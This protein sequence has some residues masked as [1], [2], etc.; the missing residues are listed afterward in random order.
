ME[1]NLP[2]L[3]DDTRQLY[4]VRVLPWRKVPPSVSRG[5]SS[6]IRGQYV[7][8]AL[9]SITSHYACSTSLMLRTS[10]RRTVY[11]IYILS[12]SMCPPFPYKLVTID[13]LT[14]NLFVIMM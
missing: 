2:S 8:T 9:I 4:D 12:H 3:V 6:F 13:A 1:K 10:H 11:I 5:I 14:D 7:T